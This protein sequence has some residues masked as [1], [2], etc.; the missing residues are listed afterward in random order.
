MIDTTRI[1]DWV[2]RYRRA[3]VSDDPD[4]IAGRFTPDVRYFTAPCRQAIAGREAVLAWWR[5]EKE[6]EIPWT[7]EYEVI[8]WDD[9]Y[10]VRGITRY[11]E[12]EQ[13]VG[14]AEIFHNRW[15]VTVGDGGRPA[16]SSSTGCW[17]NRRA[18]GSPRKRDGSSL[19]LGEPRLANP[20]GFGRAREARSPVDSYRRGM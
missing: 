9:R 14:H 4:E 19:R 6:S 11:P 13:G 17:R 8:A 10:V 2:A 1:D 12:G 3:W 18:G 7:F 15:L 20:A 5:E 16:S